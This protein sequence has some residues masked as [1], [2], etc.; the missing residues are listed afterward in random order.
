[1]A[2]HVLALTGLSLELVCLSMQCGKSAADVARD[3]G[4]THMVSYLT[5]HTDRLT[6]RSS[7]PSAPTALPPSAPPLPAS[8][9][10][11][12]LHQSSLCHQSSSQ[13]QSPSQHESSPRH[14]SGPQLARSASVGVAPSGGRTHAVGYPVIFGGFPPSQDPPRALSRAADSSGLLPARAASL[15]ENGEPSGSASDMRQT[16]PVH[17]D[18]APRPGYVSGAL[19]VIAG[20]LPGWAKAVLPEMLQPSAAPSHVAG[21]FQA[22]A[23]DSS[24]QQ[25]QSPRHSGP[26]GLLDDHDDGD[27]E[28]M[29]TAEDEQV[30]HVTSKCSLTW[31]KATAVTC[32][33]A[34]C[35][36]VG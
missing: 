28:V 19:S 1:M 16:Q 12:T 5:H 7:L 36:M 18:A 29:Q 27:D 31:H 32:D 30:P 3:H 25:Q 33:F 26:Y 34:C 21:G 11:S 4:H 17:A 8:E 22:E 23:V 9:Y 13:H 14:G 6:T 24:R 15:Q 2:W 35:P 10:N 20:N